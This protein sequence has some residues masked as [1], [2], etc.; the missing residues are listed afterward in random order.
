MELVCYGAASQGKGVPHG[1]VVRVGSVR[2]GPSRLGFYDIVPVV[3]AE[4][5]GNLGYVFQQQ[6]DRAM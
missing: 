3:A 5:L 1:L 4:G 2:V 6:D